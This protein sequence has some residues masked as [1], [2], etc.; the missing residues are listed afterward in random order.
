[1]THA[2]LE[3]LSR[4]GRA[5]WS[6]LLFVVALALLLLLNAR[7]HF[8]SE[9]GELGPNFWPRLWLGLLLALT[10]LDV[11][12][13]L[14][15][16]RVPASEAAARPRDNLRLV[17]AG[18]VYVAAYAFAMVLAGFALA[19]AVFLVAFA[20]LGGYRNLRVLAPT[21]LAT[22]VALLYLFVRVVYISLPLG[23]GPFVGMNVA[24]YR[25]LGIF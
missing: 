14:L 16:V 10:A 7:G 4:R 2:A 8:R 11:A 17:A 24:L 1:M 19:T 13:E 9:A 6:L 3:F 12:A 5:V 15:W 23:E 25:L 21:A 18:T 20:H 22:T